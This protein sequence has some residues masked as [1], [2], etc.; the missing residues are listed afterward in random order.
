MKKAIGWLMV[1]L[2]IA[3]ILFFYWGWVEAACIVG[4]ILIA[5]F[6]AIG[7]MAGIDNEIY[8][9]RSGKGSDYD[10]YTR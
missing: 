7:N 8:T 9:Y 1:A 4:F 10:R 6:R 3:T 5:L 2:V